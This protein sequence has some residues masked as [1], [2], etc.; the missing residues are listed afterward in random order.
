MYTVQTVGVAPLAR[1][2]TLLRKRLAE[3]R[4]ALDVLREASTHRSRYM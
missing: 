4:T 2:Y 3:G 1:A